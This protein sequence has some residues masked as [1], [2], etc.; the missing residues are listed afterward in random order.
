LLTSFVPAL[1]PVGAAPGFVRLPARG[2][3]LLPFFPSNAQASLSANAVPEVAI[4][5]VTRSGLILR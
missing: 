1:P 2:A 3:V 4:A 5:S